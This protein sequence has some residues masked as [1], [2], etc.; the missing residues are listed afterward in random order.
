MNVTEVVPDK[1]TLGKQFKKDSQLIIEQLKRMTECDIEE[2]EK[3]LNDK[4]YACQ[5]I[6]LLLLLA[7]WSQL[8]FT[9]TVGLC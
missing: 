1:K 2:M 8:S 4:G 6:L 5:T 3:S 7:N 9:I